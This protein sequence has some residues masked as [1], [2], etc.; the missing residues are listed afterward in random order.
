MHRFQRGRGPTAARALVAEVGR[1]LAGVCAQRV[2]AEPDK[3]GY[4]ADGDAL[5]SLDAGE[6]IDERELDLRNG[7][8]RGRGFV[9][10]PP[11][12]ARAQGIVVNYQFNGYPLDFAISK[13]ERFAVVTV[14]GTTG[15]TGDTYVI[16]LAQV[17]F[18]ITSFAHPGV[19]LNSDFV[20]ITDDRIV[21]TAMTFT[22]PNGAT[23][24]YQYQPAP[25]TTIQLSTA[26]ANTT[27][28]DATDLSTAIAYGSLAP[29]AIVVHDGGLSNSVWDLT[30][31]TAWATCPTVQAPYFQRNLGAQF[32][33]GNGQQMA[34]SI[35]VTS[36]RAIVIK[37]DTN[38]TASI[39]SA[40]TTGVRGAVGIMHLGAQP[41]GWPITDTFSLYGAPV[42]PNSVE[43]VHDLA[44]TPRGTKSVVSGTHLI[45]VYRNQN[46]TRQE[47]LQGNWLPTPAFHSPPL[48]RMTAD[49]VEATDTRAVVIGNYT[50][51]DSRPPI[52][53]AQGLPFAANDP[54]VFRVAVVDIASPALYPNPAV[55]GSMQLWNAVI[56]PADVG[57]TA[58]TPR[59]AC[60]LAITPNGSRAIVATRGGTMVLDLTVPVTQ[61]PLSP[62]PV[63]YSAAPDPLEFDPSVVPTYFM[64]SDSVACTDAVAVVIGQSRS[65][66]V[67]SRAGE[68]WILDLA[69]GTTTTLSLGTKCIPSDV[70]ITPDGTRAIVR[71]YNWGATATV[72]LGR[73]TV[74]DLATKSIQLDATHTGTAP[75]TSLGVAFGRDHLETSNHFAVS[76]GDNLGNIGWIQIIKL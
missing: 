54:D 61:T 31:G 20:E 51:H 65:S 42:D 49:S 59:R 9:G 71:S 19:T 69:V 32:S 52:S 22:S 57:A 75:F 70:V 29:I 48:C 23:E 30:T 56:T 45:A 21:S 36:N 2:G 74:V 40:T 11:L 24:I 5:A 67:N 62:V 26:P 14:V 64:V 4:D 35:E 47:L 60:D 37:N 66:I 3:A 38:P 72:D 53:I 18:P 25:G 76:G 28:G 34:D 10:P 13:D 44:V 7:R 39:G 33:T 6:L 16:D 68:I 46:G 12:S 41:S 8:A 58:A 43:L 27:F 50:A 15:T 1:G 17:G 55:P 73:I 63:W